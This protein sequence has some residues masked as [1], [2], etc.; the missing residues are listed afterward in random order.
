MNLGALPELLLS[1]FKTQGATL[2][3]PGKVE[4]ATAFKPGQEYQGSVLSQLPGGRH[5][6]RV[7]GQDLAMNLPKESQS[8][9][10]VRL[11]FLNAGPR[12]TFL[13]NSPSAPTAGS[14]QPVQLS[15]VTQQIGALLRLAGPPASLVP[16]T[17]SAMPA[18]SSVQT[19]PGVSA[20]AIRAN[21]VPMTSSLPEV[22][23]P[24][25][26]TSK[27]VTVPTSGPSTAPAK[28]VDALAAAVGGNTRPIVTSLTML[29]GQAASNPAYAGPV[30]SSGSGLPAEAI[31]GLRAAVP[32]ST[33]LNAAAT[34]Q[35]PA[36]SSQIL[37]ERLAQTLRES[38][39]FYEAHLAKWVKGEWPYEKLLVEPQN[40]TLRSAL[41]H[42]LPPELAGMSEESA[43]MAGR[44]LQILEGGAMQ[45]LGQVWAGQWMHWMVEERLDRDGGGGE[46]DQRQWLTEI[47]MQLPNLGGV[48]A[49]LSLM[50][51]QISLV[52]HSE[53]A[54]TL[55]RMRAELPV[56]ATGLQSAGLQASCQVQDGQHG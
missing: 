2:L 30:I 49:R 33:T 11:T 18:A 1:W 54:R 20:M 7:A 39:L 36:P 16:A 32:S 25:M 56:L 45:W 48:R 27:V 50:G 51:D 43:R 12:P 29:Q 42:N 44:Q 19:D 23:S 52:L 46:S 10:T 28:Y 6:V 26:P 3:Q 40:A 15:G 35:L 55:E 38:G 41:P 5:L 21:S 53:D 22:M 9:E 8:G 4:P 17:P 34:V 24:G 31:G 14:N 37:P 13:L 47:S